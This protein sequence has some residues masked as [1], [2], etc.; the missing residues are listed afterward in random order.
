VKL[1]MSSTFE[2]FIKVGDGLPPCEE[3][4]VDHVCNHKASNPFEDEEVNPTAGDCKP[5]PI[6]CEIMEYVQN[7][8]NFL[9]ASHDNPGCV[10]G[11]KHYPCNY[12]A[13]KNAWAHGKVESDCFVWK[14]KLHVESA[15]F[16]CSLVIVMHTITK[17]L[18]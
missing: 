11:V 1:N 8:S 18:C 17:A 4:D 12:K 15:K 9:Q 16:W 3:Q 5:L 6:C 10:K 7:Y 13:P 14:G 2:Q